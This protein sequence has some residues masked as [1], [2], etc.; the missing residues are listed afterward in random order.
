MEIMKYLGN[1]C[2]FL[3][4][5]LSFD[6][7]FF[8]SSFFGVLF[9]F[10][11]EGGESG[12]ELDDLVYGPGLELKLNW[13]WLSLIEFSWSFLEE[14]DWGRGGKMWGGG[15]GKMKKSE[16]WWWGVVYLCPVSSYNPGSNLFF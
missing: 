10:F 15:R 11:E 16:E 9:F 13:V 2:L 6:I 14:G 3:V 7:F 4:I 1:S 12:E 5:P 8:W